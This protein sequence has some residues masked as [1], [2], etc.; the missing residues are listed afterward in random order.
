MN[1][2]F[3]KGGDTTWHIRNQRL[4]LRIARKVAIQPVA[5]K[6]VQVAGYARDVKERS[7]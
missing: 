4:L 5:L 3:K 2:I 6:R 1:K 7:N